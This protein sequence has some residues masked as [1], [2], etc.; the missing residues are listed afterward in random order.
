MTRLTRLLHRVLLTLATG[1]MVRPVPM[2]SGPPLCPC[3]KAPIRVVMCESL[4]ASGVYATS[5]SWRDDHWQKEFAC[6]VRQGKPRPGLTVPWH[7][8]CLASLDLS[9]DDEAIY[10]NAEARMMALL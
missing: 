1:R 2:E 9:V 5:F 3:C 4:G 10:P 6:L 8:D 7:T